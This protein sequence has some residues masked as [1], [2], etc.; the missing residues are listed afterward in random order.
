VAVEKSVI[1]TGEV[2]TLL[3]GMHRILIW[4]DIRPDTGVHP[5]LLVYHNRLLMQ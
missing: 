5:Y 4:L 2:M 1:T 3:V